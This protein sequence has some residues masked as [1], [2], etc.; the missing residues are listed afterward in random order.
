MAPPQSAQG[1]IVLAACWAHARRKFYDVQQ[2]IG[3]P[4]AEEALRR[5][6]SLYAVKAE[7]RG[8]SPPRRLAARIPFKSASLSRSGGAF[9]PDSF[10]GAAAE[11]PYAGVSPVYLKTSMTSL[12]T[13]K[14]VNWHIDRNALSSL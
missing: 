7:I 6:G 13:I 14:Y 5:I 3:S 11:P 9:K 2:A 1:D 8:Q 10:A 12:T 4:I